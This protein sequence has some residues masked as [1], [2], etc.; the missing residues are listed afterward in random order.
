MIDFAPV[1]ERVLDMGEIAADLTAEDLRRLTHEMIDA[2]EAILADCSDADVVFVPDDPL[3][4]DP[5]A[6]DPAD[7]TLSWTLGHVIA[8]M[9]AS[10]EEAAFKAAEMARGVPHRKIRS[11]REVPWKS[12]TTLSQLQGRLEESRRMRLASLDMWPDEPYL[13]NTYVLKFGDHSYAFKGDIQVNAIT[14]FVM[15]LRHDDDHLHQLRN[16]VLQAQSARQ[17]A[18]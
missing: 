8:H 6:E 17:P 4:H 12:L 2:I 14:R 5:Y 7:I 3:A 16:I 1:R 9:T 10:S 15:G 18:R 11:R 13:D